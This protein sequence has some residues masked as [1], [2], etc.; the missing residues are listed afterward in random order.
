MVHNSYTTCTRALPIQDIC[1][2]PVHICL[3][4]IYALLQCIFN[5]CT[6]AARDFA[7]IYSQSLRAAGVYVSKIP[8]S[9]GISDIYHLGCTHLIGERTTEDSSHLFYTVASD[10]QLW[11]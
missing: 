9:H 2:V 8:S 10:N 11:F 6:T 1:T 4:E 3:N 5:S 7:D